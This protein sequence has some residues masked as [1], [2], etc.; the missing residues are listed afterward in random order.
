MASTGDAINGLSSKAMGGGVSDATNLR[1]M[2]STSEL[3][4]MADAL[5]V[6]KK[7]SM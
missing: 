4:L 3:K 1:V 2:V 6:G 5:V 7:T